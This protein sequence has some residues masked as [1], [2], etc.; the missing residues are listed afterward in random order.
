MFPSA[1]LNGKFVQKTG[2]SCTGEE[3]SMSEAFSDLKIK[4]SFI[5]KLFH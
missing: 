4:K 5:A 1:P 2:G 3:A